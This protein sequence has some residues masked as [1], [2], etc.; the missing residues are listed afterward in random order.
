M[1]TRNDLINQ[2][3]WYCKVW[4]VGKGRRNNLSQEMNSLDP[5]SITFMGLLNAS[6]NIVATLEEGQHI[7]D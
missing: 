1:M 7:H 6:A 3:A 2:N 5:D 4:D